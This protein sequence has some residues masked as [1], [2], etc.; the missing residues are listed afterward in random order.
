[1]LKLI[2]LKGVNMKDIQNQSEEYMIKNGYD[3]QGFNSFN[4]NKNGFIEVIVSVWK[5]GFK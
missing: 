2:T 4:K 5:D 3:G 1:M